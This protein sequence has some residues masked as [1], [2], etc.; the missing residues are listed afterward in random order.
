MT[1]PKYILSTL[2]LALSIMPA[3]AVTSIYKQDTDYGA[4][5]SSQNDT[6]GLGNFATAY[7]NFT[8]NGNYEITQIDWFGSY[9]NPPQA[10]TISAWTVT[11]YTDAGGQPGNPC[12]AFVVPGNANETFVRDD[13]V[14]DP[15]YAY[16]LNLIGCCFQPGAQ[17]WFSL[18]PTLNDPPQWGWETGT[19]GDGI[20]YQDF[21][22]NRSQ[23]NADMA[24]ELWG[25]PCGA[26]PEPGTLGLLGTGVL[27]LCGFLRRRLLG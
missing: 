10:G 6:G 19:G 14:G 1:Y 15:T 25:V 22:Y 26:T 9:Y 7:D 4:A 11:F 21:F 17:Y 3:F 27:G 13:S 23:L 20:A 2:L 16:S 12:C 5:Y 8:L 24:F 18:V